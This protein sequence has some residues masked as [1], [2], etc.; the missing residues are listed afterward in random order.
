MSRIMID[1]EPVTATFLHVEPEG[2]ARWRAAPFR[3]LARWWFRALAGAALDRTDIFRHERELFGSADHPSPVALRAFPMAAAVAAPARI[4]PSSQA[5]PRYGAMRSAI[6]PA[7]SGEGAGVSLMLLPASPAGPGPAFLE[8]VY[9]SLWAA[10]HFGGVGQRS[11]RGGGSLRFRRVQGI[12]TPGPAHA[13][14]AGNLATALERGLAEARRRLRLGTLRRLDRAEPEFPVLHPACAKAWV[15]EGP[16]ATSELAVRQRLMDSRRGL[17]GHRPDAREPEFG[18]AGRDRLA[19]PVWVRVAAFD[20]QRT[21]FVVTL[22]RHAAARGARWENV[23]TLVGRL[24]R[25]VEV[26]LGR[27]VA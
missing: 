8:Q 15:V 23:E 20:Q 2:P 22:F 27:V 10:C 7:S 17:P 12:E 4:N 19:S 11:R 6:L 24:G 3:G 18:F 5:G 16:G 1:I 9:A 13:D 25:P 26:N 21:L 14:I